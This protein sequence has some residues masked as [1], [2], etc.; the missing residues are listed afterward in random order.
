MT[1]SAITGKLERKIDKTNKSNSNESSSLK[2][3]L[4][5]RFGYLGIIPLTVTSAGLDIVIGLLAEC[6]NVTSFRKRGKF[7]NG[8]RRHMFSFQK[9]LPRIHHQLILAINPKAEFTLGGNHMSGV[10]ADDGGFCTKKIH[11]YKKIVKYEN[12]MVFCENKEDV[13]YYRFLSRL[14][15]IRELF[16]LIGLRAVDGSIAMVVAPLSLVTAGKCVKINNI[17]CASLNFPGVVRDVFDYESFLKFGLP[18]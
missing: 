10:C 18:G 15:I 17:A 13:S 4:A 12:K 8:M 14:H 5:V 9:L 3:D 1:F 7:L 11:Q 6:E 16:I 2:K